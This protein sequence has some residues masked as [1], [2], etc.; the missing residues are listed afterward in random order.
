MTPRN[1][2]HHA[3]AGLTCAALAAVALAGLAAATA[4]S[5]TP[6]QPAT[7]I[8]HLVVIFEE[9]ATFDHYFGAYP[10]AANP[11]GEPAFTARPGT[12]SVNGL[13]ETL[14]TDNPNEDN[15]QR[16]DRAQALTCDQDHHYQA[17]QEAYDGGLM[18]KFVQD[19]A[20]SE[21]TGAEPGPTGQ[22][23]TTVMDYYDGNTITALWNY[24]QY[25]TLGDNSFQTQFGP[26]TPGHLN[27]ISGETG[28]AS[29]TKANSSLANGSLI[30]N[31]YPAYDDCV[32]DGGKPGGVSSAA[33]IS[34]SGRNV[35]DLLN[36][37]GVT[38]GW[39]Q[40]GFTPTGKT[41]EGRAECRS[42]HANLGGAKTYSDYVSY[43]EPFQYYASTAN[44]HHLPP[45]WPGAV[46]HS[47]QANHQYDLSYFTAAL[48]EGNLP[49]VS[50]L[51]PSAYEDGHP[52][53]SDPLDEQRYLVDT[54]DA[55]ERSPAWPSTAIVIS[56]DDSDGWY[57]HVMAP[58]VRPSASPQDA[59]EGPGKCGAMP[60]PLPPAYQLDRCGYGPRLPL[61]VVSPWAKEDH[62]DGTLTDQSSILRF[63]EDNWQLGRI[64]GQ[65]SDAQAGTLE[66]AFD[67]NPGDSRSP[68]VLLDETTGEVMSVTAARATASTSTSAGAAVGTAATTPAAAIGRTAVVCSVRA[69]RRHVLAVACRF[70]AI[71]VHGRAAVRFRLVRHSQVLGT[72]RS[73]L[74]GSRAA[75][76]LRLAGA[77]RGSFTLRIALTSGSGVLGFVC[78]VRVR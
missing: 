12:P 72:A 52:G 1:L 63:V 35:G 55:I 56:W 46:G 29:A 39:F 57:D 30:G 75:A 2:R 5:S 51:K 14:L 43:H 74:R 45:A 65:S 59:L 40:G 61:L 64:G 47:D 24:A 53:Y 77:S 78:A 36:A 21:C 69:R 66:N 13:S 34:M 41:P 67:F 25:Y 20:G 31:A 4:D 19:T 6:G 17:E 48:S 38:W 27:L 22:N 11:P 9:N 76:M 49:A 10:H 58:I 33:L 18:D 32:G 44:E 26:S 54:I 73:P 60:S 3:T 16:L 62:V 71:H 15:P 7:P 37:Q 28:G 70:S 23:K 8:R 50:F 68:T 42:A